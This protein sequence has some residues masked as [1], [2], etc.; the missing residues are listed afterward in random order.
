ML[1]CCYGARKLATFCRFDL[2][3]HGL[4]GALAMFDQRYFS[5]RRIWPIIN[6]LNSGE[7]PMV[8]A[9]RLNADPTFIDRSTP[10]FEFIL[11]VPSCELATYSHRPC[12]NKRE[13]RCATSSTTKST[14]IHHG[15][16]LVNRP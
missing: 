16:Y 6:F 12:Y 15:S 13:P 4:R 7:Q 11:L 5:G 14:T 3:E 2:G 8:S 9:C 1:L 10:I